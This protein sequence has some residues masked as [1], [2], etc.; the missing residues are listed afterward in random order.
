MI[1]RG[2]FP[3]NETVSWLWERLHSVGLLCRKSAPRRGIMSLVLSVKFRE[4]CGKKLRNR[5]LGRD[6]RIRCRRFGGVSLGWESGIRQRSGVRGGVRGGR[7]PR[8]GNHH[9]D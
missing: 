8:D 3:H 9:K 2:E 7:I 6:R 5:C 1:L 4:I